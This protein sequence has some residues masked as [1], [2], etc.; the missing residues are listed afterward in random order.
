LVIDI[1]KRPATYVAGLFFFRVLQKTPPLTP[2]TRLA[3]FLIPEFTPVNEDV[4]NWA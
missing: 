4:K 2:D 3:Q 1:L